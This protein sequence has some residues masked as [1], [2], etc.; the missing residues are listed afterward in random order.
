MNILTLTNYEE[1]DMKENKL[2]DISKRD[3]TVRIY[4]GRTIAIGI[5]AFLTLELFA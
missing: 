3:L 5:T 1:I 2:H 4:F